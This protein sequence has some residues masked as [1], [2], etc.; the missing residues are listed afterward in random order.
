VLFGSGYLGAV[1][2]GSIFLTS[3]ADCHVYYSYPGVTPCGEGNQQVSAGTLLIPIIGPFIAAF[4]YRDPT[5]S[6]SWP[7]IDGVAQVGGLAMMVYAARHPRKVPVIAQRIRVL[8]YSTKT[9]GGL[10]AMGTF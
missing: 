7:L 4:A 8:P 3:S 10:T 9:G 6:T 1:V 5:W 2:S